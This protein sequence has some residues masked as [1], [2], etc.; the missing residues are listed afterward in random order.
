MNLKNKR[1]FISGAAGVIGKQLVKIL[2][3]EGCQIF[4]GDKKNRPEEFSERTFYK[5]QLTSI[6][7]QEIVSECEMFI[8]LAAAFEGLSFPFYDQIFKITLL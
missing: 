7:L 6:K 5:W 8:H 4:A 1:I 2:E 3:K